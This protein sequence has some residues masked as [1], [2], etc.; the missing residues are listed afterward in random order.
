MDVITIALAAG[1]F[2]VMVIMYA[3]YQAIGRAYGDRQ[4]RQDV[5]T[6]GGARDGGTHAAGF[7]NRLGED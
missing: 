1:I 2:A 3:V 6:T 4:Y 7:F 5:A